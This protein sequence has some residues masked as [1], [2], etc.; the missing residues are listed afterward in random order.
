MTKDALG[1]EQSA[2]PFPREGAITI[3]YRRLPEPYGKDGQEF[4]WEYRPD[5]PINDELAARILREVADRL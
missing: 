4:D 1:T 2:E 5:P 3:V